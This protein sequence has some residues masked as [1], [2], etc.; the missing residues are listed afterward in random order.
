MEVNSVNKNS[1]PLERLEKQKMWAGYVPGKKSP[2]KSRTDDAKSNDSST[3]L[4]FSEATDR[5]GTNVGI[6]AD[7]STLLIDFD[8][9]TKDGTATDG[10]IDDPIAKKWMDE[11]DTYLEWSPS[12]TG[13]HAIYFV[14]E[15]IELESHAFKVDDSIGRK[16]EYWGHDNRF[17]TI[18]KDRINN[19]PIKIIDSEEALK[20]LQPLGHGQEKPKLKTFHITKKGD[21]IKPWDIFNNTAGLPEIIEPHGWTKLFIDS[22]GKE[23]WKRPGKK[24]NTGSATFNYDGN[25]MFRVFSS[26]VPGFDN[27]KS[28]TKFGVY[29]VLNCNGDVKKAVKE[30]KNKYPQCNIEQKIKFN[31]ITKNGKEVIVLNTD[32]LTLLLTEHEEFSNRFRFDEFTNSKEYF[33]NDTWIKLRD[34]DI[35][36][37]QSNVSKTY[38]SFV[39]AK[40]DMVRDAIDNACYINSFDSAK[41]YFEDGMKNFTPEP[42]ILDV[43]VSKMFK[44]SNCVLWKEIG[45]RFIMGAVARVSS[46]DVSHMDQVLVLEGSQGKR[47][48]TALRILGGDWYTE[49]TQ[50]IE[51]KDFLLTLRGKLFVEFSE[52]DIAKKN[53]AQALKHIISTQV[54]EFRRPFGSENEKF[55]R[56]CSFVMSTNEDEY[57]K[58]HT[59]NRRWWILAVPNEIVIDTEWLKENRDKILLNAYYRAVV[60]KEKWYEIPPNVE[61]LIEIEQEDRVE[62]SPWLKPIVQWYMKLDNDARREGVDHEMAFEI[63]YPKEDG[64]ATKV[65]DQKD[66]NQ[67]AKV[68]K[69]SLKLK[70]GKKMVGKVQEEFY[71]PTEKT[72]KH[73][74]TFSGGVITIYSKYS[75]KTEGMQF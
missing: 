4:T 61:M 46:S 30:I 39:T 48:S 72:P 9:I 28:Y 19:L 63:I 29:A 49:T 16:Y 66:K 2:M 62:K 70:K 58:D 10:V 11:C 56:R 13:A 20:L 73:D 59:G 21:G 67:I 42:E 75:H 40:K 1:N 24:E 74:P 18:T 38:K 27:E 37:I 52:G 12:K 34:R 17:F 57:L 14:T 7:G 23:T 22:D 60:K 53:S 51:G 26:S 15:P 31:T 43:F 50:N 6:F 3:W 36:E 54:D 35:L 25:Q 45:S 68:F 71:F 44:S 8:H 64:K 33:K 55:I 65:I 32:N 41:K 47:K 5:F 69:S